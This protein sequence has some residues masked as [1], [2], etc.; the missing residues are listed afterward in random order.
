MKKEYT[1]LNG[2]QRTQL[3]TLL[4]VKTSL[5][6]I[7]H[8]LGVSRQTLYRELLRNSYPVSRDIIGLKSSCIHFLDCKKNKKSFR[9]ECPHDCIKYQPGRQSCLKK[10]PFV[11]NNCSK[12]R[13]CQFLHYYYDSEDASVNYHNRI[14]NDRKIPKTKE[15]IIKEINKIV[16]PLVKKGQSIE[17]ILINHPEIEVS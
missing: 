9:L 2:I 10:Y 11:C 8:E 7:S 4:K 12:K 17:A 15:E 13:H 14:S 1:Q 3:Q 6:D 5:S 16:S